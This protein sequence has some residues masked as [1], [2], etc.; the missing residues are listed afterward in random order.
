ML[1][2]L[3][4][5][6]LA[7]L[8]LVHST[9]EARRLDDDGVH[10][11]AMVTDTDRAG[12]GDPQYAVSFRFEPDVD[13]DQR[14]WNA[15]VDR[16]GYEQARDTQTL[17]V[18]VVPGH[19]SDYRVD[20]QPRGHGVVVLT[21]IVDVLIAGGFIVWW[22]RGRRP[23][24]QTLRLRALGDV[25][26]AR[27]GAGIE[28]LDTTTYVV[29]GEVSLIDDDGLV[30]D[31]GDRSVRIDLDGHHNPVGYQQSARVT[32]RLSDSSP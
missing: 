27:P 15:P 29:T 16:A 28:Q 9:L 13:P 1:V 21:V 11:Q 12:G 18:R 30:L 2:A 31:V 6:A 19:P 7:N 5:I 24:A 17:G 4:L 23:G 25:Q 32:G 26:R 10:V 3:V 14:E 20:G 22:R 8:P